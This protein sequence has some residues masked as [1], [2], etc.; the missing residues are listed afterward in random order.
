M[1]LGTV[2]LDSLE[3]VP[4]SVRATRA[5]LAPHQTSKVMMLKAHANT[6]TI[7]TLC[8][9]MSVSSC[10]WAVL[11]RL[12]CSVEEDSEWYP[13]VAQAGP[14]LRL[15]LAVFSS[16]RPR[17]R[18]WAEARF[19]AVLSAVVAFKRSILAVVTTLLDGIRCTRMPAVARHAVVTVVR[20]IALPVASLA[21][22]P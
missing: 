1:R 7:T 17:V 3:R 20:C 6:A 10:R 22:S 21:C 13:A 2:R 16:A 9:V 8:L 5:S 11:S 14:S 15:S 12:S 18:D 19:N 4:C